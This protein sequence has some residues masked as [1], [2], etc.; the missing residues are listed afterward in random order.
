[1]A[2]HG[3]RTV[4]LGGR[5]QIPADVV[6]HRLA[7]PVGVDHADQ[8]AAVV[9]DPGVGPLPVRVRHHRGAP[10]EVDVAGGPAVRRALAGH[11]ALLVV[12]VL[13]L[14]HAVGT[15]HRTDQAGVV[16]AVL[17]GAER[18]GHRDQPTRV[19]VPVPDPAP[20]RRP[21]GVDPAVDPVDL[22]PAAAFVG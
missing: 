21:H 13:H 7:V 17:P 5:H 1:V 15:D 2:V 19:V 4:A 3:H 20:V 8:P 11:P 9:G 18:P 6:A 16:P 10:G 12:A 22:D 14:D